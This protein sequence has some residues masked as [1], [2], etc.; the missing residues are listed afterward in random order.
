MEKR[1][2]LQEVVLENLNS[3]MKRNDIRTLPNTILK[4]K[5]KMD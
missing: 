5:L 4:D 2:S 3:Y 1:S